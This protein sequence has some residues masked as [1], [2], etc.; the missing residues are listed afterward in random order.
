M[1]RLG[2][3][4]T[5]RQTLGL[6]GLAGAA[7]VTGCRASSDE[8]AAVRDADAVLRARARGDGGTLLRRW[9]AEAVRHP[10]ELLRGRRPGGHTARPDDPDRRG[11]VGR[12]LQ[13]LRGRGG[14][15]LAL[16]RRGLVL[17]SRLRHRFLARLPG[18]RCQR[19]GYL[20]DDLPGLVPR[21]DDP[22]PPEAAHL[23]RR[24][25][26]IRVH[27]SALLLGDDDRAGLR[28]RPILRK[29]H[30]RH[31]E[32]GRRH[33]RRDRRDEPRADGWQSV[34]GLHG[35]RDAGPVGAAGGG[36]RRGT[37]ARKR[38]DARPPRPPQTA[39]ATRDR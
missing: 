33:L 9:E 30:A 38:L 10:C 37:P 15:H 3:R 24:D 4:I 5:R 19:R 25:R 26:D 32:R 28:R 8:Q 36:R 22:H 31:L 35:E 16:R 6:A 7:Y 23:R 12:P 1:S 17:G 21:P 18:D 14:R 27:V 20:Q 39:G 34:R 13:P 29:R 11:R 2:H